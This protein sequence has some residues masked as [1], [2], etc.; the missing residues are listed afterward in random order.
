VTW[1]RQMLTDDRGE[2]DVAVMMTCVA[3]L[4]MIAISAYAVMVNKQQFDA[5]QLG[6]GIAAVIAA[7]GAS[8]WG[9]AK[10]RSAKDGE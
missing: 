8:K 2:F 4:A 3:P 9:D 6:I 5:N 1:L 7:L 10:V